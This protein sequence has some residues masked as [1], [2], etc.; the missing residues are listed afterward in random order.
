MLQGSIEHQIKFHKLVWLGVIMLGAV[1]CGY[2][3]ATNSWLLAVA[4]LGG[5]WLFTLPYHTTLSM[6][7][8][9]A[10][11]SS[12]LIM[13]LFPGRPYIWEFAALLG[14]S[15]L[16]LSIFMRRHELDFM[17]QI[18]A[19]RWLFNG[20]VGYLLILIL[21]M[22]VRGFGL[23]ILGNTQMGGRYYFQQIACGIFPWLFVIKPISEKTLL[24]LLTLQC[25]LTSTFVITDFVLAHA[26]ERL[27]F[28][29]QFFELS[30]DAAN[31]EIRAMR[32]GI[33]R[34][35]SLYTVG[36]GA[37]CMLLFYFNLRDFLSKKGA[38]LLPFLAA[39]MGIALLS[40]HRYLAVTT[41]GVG[42]I[43][44]YAQRFF[45]LRQVTLSLVP[46]ALAFFLIYAYAERLPLAAQRT[47]S[48]LPGITVD[49][50][51]YTDGANTLD[52]RRILVRE[53]FRMIPMY[54]W[55]GRGFGV[56]AQE[57]SGHWDPTGVTA[58][59]IQGR[60]YNGFIGLMINTG[61]FGTI[62]MLLF[63]LGGTILALRIIKHLRTYGCED[64]F[65]R[66]CSVI[67]GLW[68]ANALA[69]LFLHGDSEYAMKTFSLQA[70]LLL[71]CDR[72]LK[73]RL[74]AA[75]VAD[76]SPAG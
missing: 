42:L 34:F 16:V 32:F 17:G 60:F 20:L 22:F 50:E 44:A 56:Q 6:Y 48:F 64:N 18:K 54:F 68:I 8:A 45:T 49:K 12:A 55:T 66:L 46:L 73:R 24:R 11:F 53:G 72:L 19:N 69:F 33:R 74:E 52:L 75:P 76:P 35:Q 59:L 10:T 38:F 15:G 9:V 13:P 47:V 39:V 7:L 41:T 27:Y 61:V 2:A 58:H 29:F 51:A 67:A 28:A 57:Y 26:P 4:A 21:T 3:L 30:G 31:F 14:W 37:F 5:L 36:I 70:G 23:R 25:L 40:G 63:I 1:A 71:A 43:C 65:S 62:S